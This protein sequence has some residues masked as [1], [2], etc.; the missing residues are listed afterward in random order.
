MASLRDH[1]ESYYSPSSGAIDIALRTGLVTP[2]TN[3][4]LSLYRLQ[5]MARDELFR[6]LEQ[7]GDQLWI[8]N[9]VALEFHQNRL[10]VIAEQERFFDNAKEDLETAV[11]EYITGCCGDRHG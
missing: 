7:L 4:L 8:P 11:S 5:P 3:V 10:N 2:D 6:I 1:F 9:Q